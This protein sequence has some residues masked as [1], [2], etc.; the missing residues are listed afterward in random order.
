MK[1]RVHVPGP[2]ALEPAPC[3][4]LVRGTRV[5]QWHSCPADK[6]LGFGRM[7]GRIVYVFR[8]TRLLAIID[9]GW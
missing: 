2:D 5:Q 8:R 7:H 4:R 3:V 1:T 9:G 6:A